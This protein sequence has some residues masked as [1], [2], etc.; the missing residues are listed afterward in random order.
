MT[1][2]TIIN[3]SNHCNQCEFWCNIANTYPMLFTK[4]QT[5][6]N[7]L[8]SGIIYAIKLLTNND[9]ILIQSVLEIYFNDLY[10]KNDSDSDSDSDSNINGNHERKIDKIKDNFIFSVILN[11]LSIKIIFTLP[12]MI[13]KSIIKN[14]CIVDTNIPI[15][16]IHVLYGE[17]VSQLISFCLLTESMN[18][19]NSN[20]KSKPEIIPNI[21]ILNNIKEY[22]LEENFNEESFNENIEETKTENKNMKNMKNI[23]YKEYYDKLL[24]M[25]LNNMNMYY[26]FYE[27]LFNRE[28]VEKHIRHNLDI[29]FHNFKSS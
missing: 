21:Y 28:L 5:N 10:S 2:K 24:F 8:L 25:F 18:L 3:K 17:S 29:W 7:K 20:C 6:K 16:N 12:H 22:L 13:H 19:I 11:F 14:S 26:Q 23:L 9:I 1:T 4:Y 15:M 27:K